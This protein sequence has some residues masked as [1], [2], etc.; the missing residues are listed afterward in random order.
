[1]DYEVFLLSSIKEHYDATGDNGGSVAS[2]LASTARVI[3][4]AA[5]VMV[6]VF[7]T[8][9]MSPVRSLKEIGLGL[10]LAIAVDA[11]LVRM[12]LVPATME[13]LG[14]ANWW[15]PAWLGRLLPTLRVDTP[16]PGPG[17]GPATAEPAGAG[18]E[19][20][21]GRPDVDRVGVGG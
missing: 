13:L 7:G 3:T 19:P 11:T 5:T 18:P 21:A 12:V 15:M 1:M 20:G 10:A 16:P 17:L 4:A 8:F 14:R 2:G 6:V 9:L